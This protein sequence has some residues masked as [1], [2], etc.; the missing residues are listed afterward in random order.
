MLGGRG[1][2]VVGRG[3]RVG[4]GVVVGWEMGGVGGH[5]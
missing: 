2:V 5:A 1:V 4:V 3:E